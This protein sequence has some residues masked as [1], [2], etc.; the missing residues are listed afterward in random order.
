MMWAVYLHP[1]GSGLSNLSYPP[2]E[3]GLHKT[4]ENGGTGLESAALNNIIK[5][6]WPDIRHNLL[7]QK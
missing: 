5:E 1:V 6:F 2:Q 7:R 3:R 4:G